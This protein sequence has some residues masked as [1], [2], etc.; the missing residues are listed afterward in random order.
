[1]SMGARVLELPVDLKRAILAGRCVAYIGSGV[2]SGCYHCWHKLVKRLCVRCGICRQVSRDTPARQLLEAAEDAKK[3]NEKKYYAFLGKHFGRP[4]DKAQLLYDALLA[5]PFDSFLTVNFDPLLALKSRTPVGVKH[6]VLKFYPSLDRK[7]MGKSSIHY[8][9]GYIG[10]GETPTPGTIVLSSGEFSEAYSE[11]SNLMNFLIPTFEN[12]PIVFIG[13]SLN[14][15]VMEEVF[16]IC[17]SHQE[18]R[19]GIMQ[20]HGGENSIP[21]PRWILRDEPEALADPL[22]VDPDKARRRSI[23]AEEDHYRTFDITPVWYPAPRGDHSA[24][25]HALEDLAGIK[26]IR[27]THGWEGTLYDT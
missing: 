15:P 16:K 7:A 6:R 8:L 21:P 27:T 2:S 4:P 3:A 5:L 12:D 26:P 22:Q 10:E 13:C 19:L 18:K 25:R 14:E 17:K 23:E 9:H 20:V 11:N 24:L 1:M